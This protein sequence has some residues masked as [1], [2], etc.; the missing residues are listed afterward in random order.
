MGTSGR[1]SIADK[2]SIKLVVPRPD[3]PRDLNAAEAIEWLAI[4][5]AMPPTYFAGSH[6]PLLAQLCR[7]T[8][9]ARQIS[10]SIAV[11]CNKKKLDVREYA[12]LLNLQRNE[13]SMIVRLSEQMRLT[14]RSVY[15]ADSAKIRP[16]PGRRP[17]NG[18]DQ[19]GY[20]IAAGKPWERC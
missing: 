19:L 13:T 11:C 4:A 5:A 7:H 9:V 16:G 6:Y 1:Q 15:R 10:K 20:R 8:V 12:R 3:P 2:S 14:H 18:G 17:A